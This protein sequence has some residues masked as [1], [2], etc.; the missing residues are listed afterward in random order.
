[1]A[2]AVRRPLVIRPPV[3]LMPSG[4]AWVANVLALL[5]L[6]ALLVAV[7]ARAAA[8]ALA[9]AGCANVTQPGIIAGTTPILFVHGIDSDP[10]TWTTGTVSGTSVAPLAYIDGAL[11]A[12]VTGYTF[13]WSRYSGFRNGSTLSW[14][15][16][17]PAPGPGQLLAEAIKC[18][19][20]KAGH[21]VIIVAHSMGGL[22]S[23]YASR[24][25]SVS[26]DIAAVFTLGTPYQGSWLD[27][28]ATGALGW[29]TQAI[30]GY[31]SG[32][33]SLNS[34]GAGALGGKQH[35]KPSGGIEALCRVVS[36]RD[37]PGM[38]GMRTDAS[39]EQGWHALSWP[40]GFPVFPLAA[41]IQ[42]TSWQ[43]L[44]LFGPQLTFADFGD[45]VVGTSSELGG[46]ATPA[47]T[48]TVPITGVPALATL[49]GAVTAS[50]CFHTNE[51]D[52]KTL[53]D[54]IVS[55]ITQRHLIPAAALAPVDWNNRHYDLTCGQIVQTPVNVAFS[56]G[57]A[58]PRGPGIGPYDRWDVSIDQVI[59][60]V[61][62]SLGAI[63]AV[64]FSCDPQPSNFAVQE[65]RIYHTADGSEIG[66]IPELPANGGALPGVYTPGSVAIANG[67]VSADVMFYGPGDSHASGPSVPGHL[68]WSWNGKEFIADASPGAACP[69]STQLLSAWNSAPAAIRQS[70][71]GPQVI[72]FSYISCWHSWVVA[73]P[74]AVS[75]G[76]G[77]VVFSQTGSLH[78]ITVTEL[79]QQFRS[80]VCSAPDA[81]S[82][83]RSPPLISCNLV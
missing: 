59:H 11:G 62:P 43:P 26:G 47:V 70:W 17:P 58:T 34:P 67:H 83:W 56:D 20:G 24:A 54:T 5:L 39:K 46:G 65:L 23:E 21:K 51:P 52:N 32:A 79:Q 27:S 64:L 14:V 12:Q 66:R 73:M 63:T 68:S 38:I 78:L 36:E 45:F 19:A 48:C 41:S 35:V 60:G 13:D 80:E 42:A 1:M 69:G 6:P 61:L 30:G 3:M 8:P 44:P 71:V 55:T 82:G 40:G 75:P 33:G 81:P 10:A 31:C 50:S 29:L 37:D 57:K 74:I 49:L 18:L 7:P 4:V 76:N 53:I 28:T 77:E 9:A 16:G 15:T 25:G 2:G 72:G 22:L